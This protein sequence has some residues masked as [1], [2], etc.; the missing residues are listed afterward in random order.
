MK[1]FENLFGNGSKIKSSEIW[2]KG[3]TLEVTLDIKTYNLNLTN[4]IKNRFELV[5]SQWNSFDN[6]IFIIYVLGGSFGSTGMFIGHKTSNLY[7]SMVE[8]S[9]SISGIN[10]HGMNNGN[11]ITKSM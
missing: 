6:G 5:K 11:W 4:S 3:N 7:G 1:V 10:V 8:I 2:H 9:Y